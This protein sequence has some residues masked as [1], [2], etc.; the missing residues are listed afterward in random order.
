MADKADEIRHEIDRG[1]QDIAHTRAAIAEKLTILEARVQA[2]VETV[3]HTFDLRYQVKQ[4]PWL[5]VG[6]ALLVGHALGRRARLASTPT[7]V[8][9]T[10]SAHPQPRQNIVREVQQQVRDDLATIKGAACG[11]VISTLWAM[12]K[13]VLLA[14][15]RRQIGGVMAHRGGERVDGAPEST[16]R[17]I[18]L[19][20]NGQR[21]VS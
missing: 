8:P 16:N 13:Q 19:T 1:R 4:R 18:T 12:A 17:D 10:P 11:A 9:S 7:D 3:K 6:A 14:P 21:E 15:P 2:T 5:M 20:T